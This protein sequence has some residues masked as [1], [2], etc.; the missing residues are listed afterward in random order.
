MKLPGVGCR[1]SGVGCRVGGR[2]IQWAVFS[3]Q[4]RE[5]T[6][7]GNGRGDC[8]NCSVGGRMAFCSEN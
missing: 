7:E 2:S 3:I 8:K 1:V 5:A 4:T 6:G